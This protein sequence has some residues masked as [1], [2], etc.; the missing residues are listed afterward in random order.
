MKILSAEIEAATLQVRVC[1]WAVIG[2]ASITRQPQN[3]NDRSA[4]TCHQTTMEI[5]LAVRGKDYVLTYVQNW[6]GS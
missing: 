4:T 3:R 5:L 1:L 2:W 6:E